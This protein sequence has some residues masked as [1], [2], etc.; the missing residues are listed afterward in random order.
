MV[1]QDAW[2]RH[3]LV[4]L[5]FCSEGKEHCYHAVVLDNVSFFASAKSTICIV[6][7][8]MALFVNKQ[9]KTVSKA[10]WTYIVSEWERRRK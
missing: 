3:F 6:G 4:L 9:E 2:R 10:R 5:S 7:T 8:I 1:C